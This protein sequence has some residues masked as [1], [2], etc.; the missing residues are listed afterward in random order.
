MTNLLD[1]D[2]NHL[3][4]TRSL[5]DL[6]CSNMYPFCQN[7]EDILSRLLSNLRYGFVHTYVE[8]ESEE[9][10]RYDSAYAEL[11]RLPTRHLQV[12]ESVVFR[13]LYEF[14]NSTHHRIDKRK[15][16]DLLVKQDPDRYR[17]PFILAQFIDDL[18]Y[19]EMSA[20]HRRL[21]EE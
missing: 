20:A 3:V 12:L 1:D 21:D 17:V 19:F 11:S 8:H 14:R 2:G 15:W 7:H 4:V 6:L 5:F 9:A 18:E 10:K 16:Y 13:C